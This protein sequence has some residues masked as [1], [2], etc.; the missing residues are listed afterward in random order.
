MVEPV[1]G[2]SARTA[3][4]AVAVL[5]YLA[6]WCAGAAPAGR[7]QAADDP[8][9]AN[10]SRAARDEAI[11]SI[12][13]DKL[14]P[15]GKAKVGAIL[16]DISVFRRMPTQVIRCDPDLY[17]FMIK[18]PDVT[19][20]LWQVLGIT[21]VALT[22]TGEG[23]FTADD[24]TGTKGDVQYLYQSH[25][26]NL[27]YAVG[28]YEGPL[29]HKPVQGGCLLLLKTGYIR[30]PSG[31][32]YITS[33]LDAFF[34]L[35]H[36]GVEILA[37]TFQPLVGKSADYNFIESNNFLS[38]LSTTSETRPSA[39]QHLAS[40]LTKVRA[41]DREEFALI[42]AA[43]AQ[44]ASERQAAAPAAEHINPPSAPS[45]APHRPNPSFRR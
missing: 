35:K 6:A 39:M 26:L 32:Y 16:A 1:R 36:M 27:I 37:K 29:F 15:D 33:Q 41:E 24:G 14:D 12:P 42:V 3:R 19:V 44:K 7:L 30:E 34:S 28:A 22:R 21:Q 4:V 10:T 40:Q 17:L 9:K 11:R 23:T 31:E 8:S 25:D 13:Y 38:T 18:H 2:K 20:N 45:R 43:I 5:A